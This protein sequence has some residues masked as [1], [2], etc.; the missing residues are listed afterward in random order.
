MPGNTELFL[1]VDFC[2]TSPRELPRTIFPLT[3]RKDGNTLFLISLGI[4]WRG[5]RDMAW[6]QLLSIKYSDRD[7]L[8]RAACERLA[9]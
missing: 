8:R 4:D 9:W 5:D 3:R 1:L 2:E 7:A 6:S